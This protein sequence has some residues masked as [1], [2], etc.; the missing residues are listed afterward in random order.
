M[1]VI[2][3]VGATASGKSQL[4]LQLAQKTGGA[5]FNCDSIQLYKGVRIGSA[6][7][8]IEERSSRPHYLFEVFDKGFEA[9]VG[10]YHRLFFQTIKEIT[11]DHVYVVGGTG[12]YFQALEKGL[13]PIGAVNA[14]VIHVLEEQV[15][16][17]GSQSLYD[18]LQKMDPDSAKKISINDHY[19]IIRAI[20]IIRT[21]G[22]T[23][24]QVEKEFQTAQKPFPFPLLKIGIESS[25]ESL[26][27]R[28]HQRF[29]HMLNQGVLDEVRGL[30]AEGFSNWSPLSSIGYRECQDYLRGEILEE[31]SLIDEVV[32]NTL[33]FAKRQRTWFRRDAGIRWFS[34]SDFQSVDS[35]IARFLRPS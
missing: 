2:F 24:T 4:A 32:K 12:F 23:K 21:H 19:R 34:A 11:E 1:K 35:A 30:I 15:K 14:E 27:P 25:R 3:V 22:K 8:S 10:D 16:K 6:M 18:E 13:F 17:E 31:I 29:V 33:R 9:T 20:E 28:V 5:I 26:A 7:P